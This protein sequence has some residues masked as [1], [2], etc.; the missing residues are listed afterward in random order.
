MLD[1]T[2]I[3]DAALDSGTPVVEVHGELDLRTSPALSRRLLEASGGDGAVVVDLSRTTFID[4]TTLGVLLGTAR[5]MARHGAPLV[6]VAGHEHIRRVIEL[7]GLDRVLTV[8]RSLEQARA[9]L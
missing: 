3:S 2:T 5:R 1:H 9:V 7:T 6:V 8:V 4:S